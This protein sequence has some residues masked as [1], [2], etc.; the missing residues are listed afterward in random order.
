MRNPIRALVLVSMLAAAAANAQT[1]V[2][3]HYAHDARADV[4]APDGSTAPRLQNL[5]RHRFAVTTRSAQAQRFIDQG[6]NLAYAFNHAEAG[7]SFREAARLDPACAMAYWGQA[8]VLGP[9]INAPMDT[10]DE[11]KA[12]ALVAQALE[13]RRGAS[14]REQAWIEALAKRYAGDAAKRVAGD[15]AYAEAMAGV[16]RRFPMDLDAQ[17][18][19]AEAAMDLRPWNYWRRDGTPQPGTPA[20]RERLEA[21]LAKAPEHPGALHLYIHL[22]EATADAG[23][24][25]PA[26]DRLLPL[27]PGAGHI[28]HMPS[29]IYMRV[30]RYADAVTAN[31]RAVVADEDYI[32]HCRAQG[33]YPMAYYPHNVHFLWAAATMEG[34]SALAIASARKVASQVS[35]S[36]LTTLP[37]L[38]GFR[39]VPW[40]ALTRFGHWDEMLAELRPRASDRYLLGT[41]HYARGLALIAKG[42]RDEA[43]RALDTLRAIVAEKSLEFSLFSPNT[44]QNILSVAPEVL[45]GELA[46]AR[47]DHDAAV[48]HLERAARFEDALVYTE[49]EEWH[50]PP[51][52]ALGAVLLAA[53]RAREAETVYWEDLRRHPENGWALRGLADALEAQGRTAEAAE[54]LARLA[55]VWSRADV[56]L[57]GSRFAGGAARA[58]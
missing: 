20:I 48:R 21:V 22:L 12:H 11:R 52:H 1:T 49:P 9:N 19:W 45:A 35:D 17:V 3:Q 56:E 46:A 40:Y 14:V 53:G 29:H 36:V 32:T 2:H 23:L 10:S 42:R 31:E 4:P 43:A 55:R 39:V 7:R 41:W 6:M 5:G 37:L 44:A 13:R 28:V 57:P 50:Y 24:A 26:A 33:L 47:G 18:L 27:M 38:G 34:R 54:T 30:G 16:A 15:S 8:I 51:R 25:E 58:R